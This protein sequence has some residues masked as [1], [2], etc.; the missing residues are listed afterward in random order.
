MYV[1][2]MHMHSQ[3]YTTL[4]GKITPIHLCVHVKIRKN[5]NLTWKRVRKYI[6]FV[7]I[8]VGIIVVALYE[9]AYVVYGKKRENNSLKAK[10]YTYIIY[11]FITYIYG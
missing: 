10:G 11:V 3:T 6:I 7:I 2:Y 8:L 9:S 5:K 4:N 1:S